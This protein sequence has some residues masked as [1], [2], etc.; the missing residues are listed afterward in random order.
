MEESFVVATTYL[1][2]FVFHALIAI[3]C[4]PKFSKFYII[5][6]KFIYFEINIFKEFMSNKN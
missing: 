6:P 3:M 2:L 1:F 4:T 5:S